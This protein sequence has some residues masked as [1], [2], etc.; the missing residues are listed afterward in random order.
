MDFRT[1]G[2]TGIRVSPLCLGAMMFGAVGNPDHDECVRIVHRALDAGI[3]F[4]D[5]AD[6]YSRG[7]SEEIVGKAI[8][9]RRDSLV[10][11]TKF[12]TSMSDT[13]PNMRGASRRWIVREVENSLRRLGTDY[14][15]LY[16][17]HRYDIDTD[18][19]EVLF[20]LTDLVRAGKIRQF[21]SSSLPADRIVESH[22]IAEK[23]ATMR[24]RT[25]QPPY[26][27]FNRDVERFVL[28]A[29]RRFGMGVLSYSPLDAG[30]LAGKYRGPKDFEGPNNRIARFARYSRGS[31]DPHADYI[32]RKMAIV[33]E[34]T[35][36]ADELEV[37]IAELAVAFVLQH[38]AITAA[39]IGP[40]TMQHLESVLGG[41]NLAL[42]AD[43]L[44][45]IDALCPP[46]TMFDPV[47]D[48]P[49]GTA[50]PMLRRG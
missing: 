20:T 40:R 29:C 18:I 35:K 14:I 38:P 47:N 21:G 34:L 48:L 11:A 44:D 37:G 31:F 24:L 25:E 36:L 43:T 28:P 32:R 2:A 50:K 1:L 26:S 27:I 45:R 8:K 19:E 13:D 23:R 9:G 4:I 22:W 10:I 39:I 16:Q 3:N 12:Y 42:S 7:E 15:D 41:G 49:S 46:G 5:T 30:F 17:L 6:A 33:A